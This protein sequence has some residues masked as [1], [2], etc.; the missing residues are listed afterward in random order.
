MDQLHFLSVNNRGLKNT[1]K[2]Q[3]VISQVVKSR[4]DMVLLQETHVKDRLHHLLHHHK[5]PN[6]YSAAGLS[7]SRGVSILVAR[8]VPIVVQDVL[9]NP[10][11]RYV[12]VK[13]TIEDKKIT[14][15]SIYAPNT[16]QM[17]FLEKVLD[18][19]SGFKE[20]I[21]VLG[22]NLNQV[23]DPRRDRSSLYDS[24]R[25][26]SSSHR[27]TQL[28]ERVARHDLRDVWRCCNDSSV[29]YTYYSL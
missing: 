3:R 16:G 26:C 20:G 7:K 19:L 1:T 11:G 23:M 27:G 24:S 18:T 2:P 17:E 6:F 13:G 22:C 29:N 4:A 5:F 15:A 9:Y 14:I 28:Q 10:K 25:I 12:I 21:L 8:H